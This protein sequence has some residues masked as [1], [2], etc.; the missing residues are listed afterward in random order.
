M[1]YK[2][3]QM[4]SKIKNAR[5][6]L[7]F[8]KYGVP[9]NQPLGINTIAKI[10]SQAAKDLGLE[11]P[12]EYT[13]ILPLVGPSKT[14]GYVEESVRHKRTIANLIIPNASGAET[15]HSASDAL[16]DPNP[17]VPNPN[18]NQEHGTEQEEEVQ[19]Q[20]QKKAKTAGPVYHIT[21][22]NCATVNF[23]LPT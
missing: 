2:W 12:N 22:S 14:E 7:G 1:Y 19:Q 21:F 6:F 15:A 11:H 5:L 17:N 8:T 10:P 3:I 16:D 18:P 20:K 4:R 23:G 9:K 13:G